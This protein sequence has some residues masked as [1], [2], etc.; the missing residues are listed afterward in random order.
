MPAGSTITYTITGTVAATTG[1]IS[2]V[3][4]VTPP[5][6]T[7]KTATDTDNLPDLSIT[8]VD[9]AGGS[10][11]TPS[12]GSIT[13]GEMLTY[14]IVVSN[15]GP[16]NQTGAIITDPLPSFISGAS[17]TAVGAGGAS[18]FAT[19]GTGNI[20]QTGV[21]LPAGSTITYTVT[22]TVDLPEDTNLPVQSITNTAT[23][24]GGGTTHNAT[25]TDDVIDLQISKNDSANGGTVS[26]GETMNYTVVVTNAGIGTDTVAIDDPLPADYSVT[27]WTAAN[28]GTGTATGFA[29]SGTGSIAQTGVTMP[30]GSAITYTINGSISSSATGGSTVTNTASAMPAGGN[31]VTAT[32]SDLVGVPALSIVKSDN[33]GGSSSPSTTGNVNPGQSLTYTVVVSNS[34]TG[35]ADGVTVTDP[36]PTAMPSANYTTTLAGGATDSNPTGTGITSLGDTVSLP[37]GGTITYTITGTVNSSAVG[38]LSNTATAKPTVGNAVSATDPDNLTGLEIEKADNVEGDSGLQTLTSSPAGTTGSAFDGDEL[39]YSITV[40]NIGPGKVTNASVTDNFPSGYS[41]NSWSA[42]GTTGGASD[43]IGEGTGDL[44]DSV[45]LPPGASIFYAITGTLDTVGTLSNTATVAPNVGTSVSATDTLNA[46]ENNEV[47][48]VGGLSTARWWSTV[49]RSLR[50]RP[51]PAGP[52][53]RESTPCWPASVRTSST[54]CRG[55]RLSAAGWGPAMRTTR[56][57]REA[58]M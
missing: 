38:T 35:P 40:T 30:A 22:G 32:I 55:S 31:P 29:T 34:G 26:P 10:S 13:N 33:A 45:T 46:Q 53:P 41:L 12:T 23:V 17:W 21:D 6:G 8:K 11:I 16:G 14:T 56:Q 52:A 39:D 54:R 9:N 1:S 24:T 20:N 27:G 2:N 4:S 50:R 19:S 7:K 51:A 48:P 36:L 44:F 15:S 43:T 42:T 5:G 25:D 37:I 57:T 58:P 18:G 49:P 47:A 28:T 3:A